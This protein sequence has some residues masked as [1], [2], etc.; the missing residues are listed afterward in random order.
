MMARATDPGFVS[1]AEVI[2]LQEKKTAFFVDARSA[3]EYAAGHI[4]EARNLPYYEME[5]KQAEGLKG[6]NRSDLLVIYCEGVGCELSFFLGRELQSQGYSNIR[7]FYGGYPE[8][9]QAGLS[10]EK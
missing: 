2:T 10:I 8:W 1:L 5:I 3:D 4:P 9:H 6:V 7:I